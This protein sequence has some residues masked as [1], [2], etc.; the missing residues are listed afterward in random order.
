MTELEDWQRAA[1]RNINISIVGREIV[2]GWR[3]QE[4]WGNIMAM[5]KHCKKVRVEVM[6]QDTDVWI[7]NSTSSLM[8]HGGNVGSGFG[9][10][11]GVMMPDGEEGK[12]EWANRLLEIEVKG[13]GVTVDYVWS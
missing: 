12:Q 8:A 2:E 3:R 10:L 5:L 4:G 6:L 7:G 9:M 13:E 11:W 1:L